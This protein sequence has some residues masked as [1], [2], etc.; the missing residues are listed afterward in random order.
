MRQKEMQH[1]FTLV[2]LV[3][4]LVLVTVLLTLLVP[5]LDSA[6]TMSQREQCAANLK[7][8]GRVLHDYA[9]HHNDQLP[10]AP[11]QS[12]WHYGGLRYAAATRGSF[13]DQS[14]PLNRWIVTTM[15]HA[16]A[17][18][19]FCCPADYG[20]RGEHPEVGTG[21]R[22]SCRAFGTSYR[23]N[24]VLFNATR[25][26]LTNERRGMYR[27]EITAAPS[28]LLMLGDAVWHEVYESTGRDANWHGEAGVGNVLFLDG[29]VKF[30]A[31]W[32]RQ[33]VGPITLSPF[34]PAPPVS[35]MPTEDDE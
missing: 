21:P 5:A 9:E 19:M 18:S 16:D 27:N 7:L 23:A 10:Y 25:A 35:E 3:I 33:R 22:T 17:H 13:L 4:S 24:A 31:I 11:G 1:G 15:P 6:R 30:Q 26:G 2:E 20:I 12:S 32:P 8:L 29:S 28:R 14:I 34:V